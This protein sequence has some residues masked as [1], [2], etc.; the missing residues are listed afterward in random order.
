MWCVSTAIRR[1]VLQS[2]LA[3]SLNGRAL[4]VAAERFVLAAGGI[5][6]PG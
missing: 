5:E 1:D 2:V 4:S 3:R 6:N